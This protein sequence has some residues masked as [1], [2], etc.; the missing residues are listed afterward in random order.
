MF[1][2]EK[3]NILQSHVLRNFESIDTLHKSESTKNLAN[4]KTTKRRSESVEVEKLQHRLRTD[5]IKT[6]KAADQQSGESS[7]RGENNKP[8]SHFQLLGDKNENE[9][10]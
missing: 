1:A 3:A 9:K 4:K 2:K 8:T 6:S 10:D 5:E 7:I